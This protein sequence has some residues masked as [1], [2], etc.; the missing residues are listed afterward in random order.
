MQNLAGLLSLQGGCVALNLKVSNL[1]QFDKKRFMH[2]VKNLLNPMKRLKRLKSYYKVIIQGIFIV[3]FIKLI[4]A[5][6]K[7]S[8]I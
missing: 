1:A 5:I 7:W 6:P 3:K 2:S 4:F 8:P